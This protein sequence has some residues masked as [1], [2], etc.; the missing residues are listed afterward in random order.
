[1]KKQR[2]ITGLLLAFFF[3]QI[4]TAFSAWIDFEPQTIH[5]PDGTL[6]ECFASGDEFYNWLHDEDG[7]TIIQNH[8]NGY[9]YYA[10]LEGEA[11]VPSDVLAGTGNPAANGIT[12]WTNIAGDQMASLRADFMATQMPSRPQ[13]PGYASPESTM[14]EGTLNNLVVYIRFSDQSEFTADT[15]FYYEMYNNEEQGSNSM[16]NYFETVSYDMISIP[17]WFYPVPSGATVISYQDIYERSY[18]MPYDPTTNP[19]GYIGDQRAAREHGLLKRACEFIEDEV[20]VDLDIDMNGDGYIDNMVFVVKGSTTAWSTLLWPH[21]WVLYSQ[22]V[23]IHGKQVWDYNLQVENHLNSS[24][25]GVLCHEMFHSL[26]APDLY[27]YNSAPYTSVGPWDLMD[28]NSNPPQSMGAYMK[29]KYGGWIDEIPEI[30]ECGTYTLSPI[31]EEANNC[32]KIASPYSFNEFFVLEYRVKEGVFEGGLP[33]SGL[34]VYRIDSYESGNA[35]GP[36][37]EVYVYR[38]GG[39]LNSTGNLGQAHFAADYDRTEI[40]DN[41]DPNS[42]LQYGGDGGLNIGNIGYVGE[43]IS[44]EVFFETA[45]TADFEASDILVTAG[46]DVDFYDLSVCEVDSWEWTFEG[47]IPSSSSE[48]NPEGITWDTP[49]TY[50]VTLTAENSWGSN[51]VTKTAF[52]EVSDESLPVAEFFATDTIICTQEAFSIQD[53][54]KVCPTAWQWEISP[55]TYEFV[56]GTNENS[57]HID[58]VLNEAGKYTVSLTVSNAN[59]ETTLEKED[60]LFAGGITLPFIEDFEVGQIEN[61]GW[62]IENPDEG[63]TWELFS[64]SGKG[65]DRAAGINLNDYFQIFARDQLI[66]PAI[67]LS[68]INQAFLSFEHA[69]A[70][71]LNTAYTDSLIVKISTDC[72]ETW[73]RILE[74]GEDGSYN[75]ATHEPTNSNFVP[76]VNEDWCDGGSNAPCTTIDITE[77]T[78]VPNA[79]IMF[80]SVRLTG[81]NLYVDNVMVSVTTSNED[82]AVS[83]T[84]E[85]KVYPNPAS[86][87]VTLKLPTDQGFSTL[88]VVN[89]MGQTIKEIHQLSEGSLMLDLGNAP[90]GIYLISLEGASAPQTTKLLLH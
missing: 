51:T 34:L 88:R 68:N 89:A 60:Y 6:I 85:L 70:Q 2:T 28:S 14:N 77:F 44:F 15:I 67:N 13:L 36:P 18:F 7:Y 61:K 79:R 3:M 27:H 45:P 83:T 22:N 69:Y 8:E 19:N 52:I 41:T 25:V 10:K 38:P 32:Y 76:T 4:L 46:C 35:Q 59:G 43:T 72:G 58:L 29:N 37:D 39:T 42:F 40:N 20:P 62:Q 11:L 80:E 82:N 49:G 30:T 50:T 24:G 65:G 81:N 87:L 56:N 1:M 90:R 57:Q 48:Q 17:S 12:P 84:E 53:F 5:Q 74:L 33:G 64:V 75:F 71:T 16:L 63:I 54:T 23:F 73:T 66:S 31:G 55:S 9:Y 26:G 21:R 47:G 78:G 86:G